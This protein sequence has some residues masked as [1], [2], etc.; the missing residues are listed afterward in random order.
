MK[1]TALKFF[2]I[3]FLISSIWCNINR[4]WLAYAIIS[5]PQRKWKDTNL[6]YEQNRTTYRPWGIPISVWKISELTFCLR[7]SSK[8]LILT[9]WGPVRADTPNYQ[10][11]LLWQW[12]SAF[13]TIV[14]TT[15][16]AEYPQEILPAIQIAYYMFIHCCWSRFR[17][18]K[19]MRLEIS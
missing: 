8:C 12:N 19:I 6:Q 11:I 15:K 13:Y 7:L 3:F 5:V 2:P 1:L 17:S 16:L 14:V 9:Y 4:G 18:A 10:T